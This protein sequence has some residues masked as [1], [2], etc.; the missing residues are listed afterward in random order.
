MI[1]TDPKL[2][3]LEN[4]VGE[5]ARALKS[6]G[7]ENVKLQDALRR[8]EADNKRLKE[9][10]RSSSTSRSKS[11]KLRTRLEKLAQKLEKI[12]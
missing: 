8:L 9:E 1:P 2:K 7:A 5:A 4:L 3:T 10:L 11:D 12:G 6:L